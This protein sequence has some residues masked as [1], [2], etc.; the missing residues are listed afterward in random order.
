M[1]ELLSSYLY[2]GKGKGLR[3]KGR[4]WYDRM[5][6]RG[7]EESKAEI[8]QVEML[9]S[10]LRLRPSR[11]PEEVIPT[12]VLWQT[13]L[14]NCGKPSV[15]AKKRMRE[16]TTYKKNEPRKRPRVSDYSRMEYDDLDDYDSQGMILTFTENCLAVYSS[17]F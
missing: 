17:V 11:G 5:S 10:T 8:T 6:K 14:E 16:G 7:T 4:K 15:A 2:L 13:R 12:E 9:K 3:R 1:L